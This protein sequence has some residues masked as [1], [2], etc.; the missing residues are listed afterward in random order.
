MKRLM[1]PAAALSLTLVSGIAAA[2]PVSAPPPPNAISSH[3]VPELSVGVAGGAFV[4]LAGATLITL[5]RR[6]RA[7]KL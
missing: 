2:A 6:R 7:K 4:I 5:G 1:F 3:S